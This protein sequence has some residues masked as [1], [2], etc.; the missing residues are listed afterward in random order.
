MSPVYDTTMAGAYLRGR[1]LRAEDVA[2]WMSAAAPHLPGPGGRILDLGAGTGRF[3]AALGQ[4]TGATVI[5]CEPS[6]A[7]RAVCPREGNL[8][9]GAAETPPFRRAS[10]DAVWASQVLHHV[11][12]LAAFARGIR[13]VLRP[14][15]RLLLRG[16][17]GAPELIPLHRWFP[18]AFGDSHGLLAEVAARLSACGV[19]RT[20][21]V[22]VPQRY[23]GSARELV[24]K[25]AT[26]S[27]S[28]LARLPDDDFAAG[29]RAVRRDAPGLSYPLDERLDLVVF[30]G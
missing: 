28:N 3:T 2:A 16:G 14:G 19:S 30:T 5:A 4:A 1:T 20:A 6:P 8:V 9:G 22:E 18:S 12:D 11:R 17:F 26:R 29:L 23:A 21:R 25:V 24:D 15:G 10:F 27:L 13:H 7:M